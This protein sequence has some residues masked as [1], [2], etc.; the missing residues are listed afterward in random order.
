MRYYFRDM[1]EDSLP[2]IPT[3]VEVEIIAD[4]PRFRQEE[5]D[6][7]KERLRRLVEKV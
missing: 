1:P 3:Q 2:L 7:I 5:I 4:H 6:R